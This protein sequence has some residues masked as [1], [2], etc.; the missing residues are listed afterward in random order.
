MSDFILNAWYVGAL[1]SEVVGDGLFARR[2]LDRPVL[3]YRTSA[4]TPVGATR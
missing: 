1:A 4:G 3:F 2:L